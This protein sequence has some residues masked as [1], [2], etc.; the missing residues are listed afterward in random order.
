MAGPLWAAQSGTGDPLVL[1]HGNSG[2]HRDFDRM[3][4][5]LGAHHRVVGLDSR[6]HGAS[7]RGDGD[8]TIARMADDVD[9]ALEAL[10][11]TGVDVLG[12]SDGGNVALELALRHPGRA[13][14]LVLVG[15]NLFPAG[16]RGQVRRSVAVLHRLAAL[17][18]RAFPSVRTTAERLD[19]M[20][21]DP[22]IDPDDL[23]RVDVPV[24][25]VAGERDV[26]LPEHTRLIADSLPHG[27]LAI[28]PAAGHLLPR[29]HP[30][31]LV[32]LVEEHLRGA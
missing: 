26:I 19:L 31:E 16:V 8:L 5:L 20:V 2:S 24:L 13:R 9:A 22:R 29:T 12:F 21:H 7:P 1:L 3:L 11:L 18:G 6:A 25:V 32:D 4:P 17:A 28:V 30:R 10:G 23:A 15:A 14:S 27:R